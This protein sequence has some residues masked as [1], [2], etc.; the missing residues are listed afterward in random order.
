M[1]S[2]PAS[3]KASLSPRWHNEIGDDGQFNSEFC[4]YEVAPDCPLA[5]LESAL[6]IVEATMAPADAPAIAAEL[7]VLQ[8]LTKS[9]AEDEAIERLRATAL[10]S[11]LKDYPVD[12]IVETCSKWADRNTF[13]PSWAELKDSLDWHMRKRR[14]LKEALEKALDQAREN[15]A[16]NAEATQVGA[17]VGDVANKLTGKSTND[18][19]HTIKAVRAR[20]VA[21]PLIDPHA[22]LTGEDREL[23]IV[24]EALKA[25]AQRDGNWKPYND[26][27][28]ILQE[29]DAAAAQSAG[30]RSGD[31]TEPSRPEA[32]SASTAKEPAT[33]TPM[34]HPRTTADSAAL[35]RV[36]EATAAMR[37][38]RRGTG[39]G[40]ETA[41]NP[42]DTPR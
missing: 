35:R 29:R 18:P 36:R 26:M 38:A 34:P 17:I 33:P 28:K 7:A 10:M 41:A 37:L 30:E 25:Q 32:P 21:A 9:R 4:G 24:L 5:D 14:R 39:D 16:R 15:R 42:T 6:A 22:G 40:D 8:A 27:L 20:Q 31:P 1:A 11:M 13:F 19:A 23:S 3:V 2:L 12:V